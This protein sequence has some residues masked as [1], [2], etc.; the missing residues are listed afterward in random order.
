MIRIGII[1]PSEI[2]ERR[3]LPALSKNKN[4]VFVGIGV[5]SKEERFGKEKV[6]PEIIDSILKE[7]HIKAQRIVDQYGGHVFESYNAIVSSDEIDAIYIP[8]PPGLHHFWAKKALEHGKHVLVEKPSTTNLEDSLDLVETAKKHSLALHENY[9]FVFHKQIEDIKKLISEGNIGDIRLIRIDF[10]FPMRKQNDFRYSKALG[11]GAL[12]DAGGY[13]LKLANIL[14]GDSAQIKTAQVNYI[15]GFEVEMYGSAT[16][17]NKDG[18]TAQISFGM[19]NEYRC[20]LDV[21]G[22]KG[23]LFSGRI[24]TAPVGFTP[25][26]TIING[27]VKHEVALSE[28]D[29]FSAS[30]NF[31]ADCINKQKTREESYKAILK[32]AELVY[33]FVS[34]TKK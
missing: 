2:A 20:N 29:T 27:G 7:E 3:F 16:L 17:V 11:G 4:F 30:I 21:W 28:D 19:D 8:L 14:L 32:Q 12:L 6:D 9:M 18:L 31:F 34:Y 33:N 13:T 26:A 22:N 10:G 1:C 24:L 5:V 23:T 15:D 25:T